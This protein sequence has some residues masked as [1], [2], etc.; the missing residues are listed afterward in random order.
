M[1]K[2]RTVCPY[3]G[4]GC[5][6]TAH[7]ENNRITAVDGFNGPTNEGRLCVKGRYGFDYSQHRNR[8]LKPMIRRKDAPPKSADLTVD[9]ANPWSVFREATWDEALDFAGGGLKR[10][11][12]QYGPKALVALGCAKGSNEEAYLV[13]KLVR[14][15]FGSNNIDHCTR[16]CH[17]GSVV[18]LGQG[19]GSGAVTLPVRDV[20]YADCV[21]LIGSNPTINHPV[22]AS[23]MKNAIDQH[24]L[25]LIIGDPRLQDMSRRAFMHLQFTPDTDVAMLNAM[26]Y[27]I[28]NEGLTDDAFIAAHTEGFEALKA[29]IQAFSPDAMERVCGVSADDLRKAAR[30]YATAKNSMIIWGMGSSQS[31]HGSDNVRCLIALAMITGQIGRRGA[32]LHPIR[33]QNNVQGASDVGLMPSAYPDYKKVTDPAVQARFEKLWGCK[34]DPKVGLTSMEMMDHAV[35][36]DVKGMYIMGENPAMSDANAYH[37]RQ[38]IANLQ[39]L[40]VQDIFLTETAYNADVV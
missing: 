21:F 10:I 38:G 22:A 6:L 19:I 2:V 13:Q 34:L 36:G 29:H 32:G 40:V 33:G 1:K 30:T 20:M 3:C 31:Q 4:V 9:P 26:I 5:Q 16:L 24:G 12:D 28:I 35:A 37:A 8:L 39:H 23:W 17:A 14:T 7:V 27:T 18:A 25:K 11:R 15:G